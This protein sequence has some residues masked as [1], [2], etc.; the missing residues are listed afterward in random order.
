VIKQLI[1]MSLLMMMLATN[2]YSYNI[3]PAVKPSDPPKQEL[4]TPPLPKFSTTS[5]DI[6]VYQS[7]YCWDRLGCADSIGGKA[8]LRG[9]ASTAVEPGTH[10]RITWEYEPHPM[11]MYVNLE[12]DSQ[13]KPAAVALENGSFQAPEEAGEYYY[14][15]SADWLTED[16][17]F[18]TN[19]TSVVIGIK[20]K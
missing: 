1:A 16:R 11:R 6:P 20:V 14:T 18:V 13:G 7:S 3:E 2:G 17:Q 9:N 19:Q 8:Q 12:D 5:E 10:I 15:I 4:K